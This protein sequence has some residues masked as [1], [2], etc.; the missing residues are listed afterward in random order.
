[1]IGFKIAVV[2]FITNDHVG[3][4][5]ADPN[6]SNLVAVGHGVE[7]GSI[8]CCTAD[9]EF[10]AVLC[11]RAANFWAAVLARCLS[12]D[13]AGTIV[14]STL[15]AGKTF[16]TIA[17]VRRSALADTS[18]SEL[19][20]IIVRLAIGNFNGALLTGPCIR[21]VARVQALASTYA[22][23][24]ILARVGVEIAVSYS[25]ITVDA[26]PCRT[27]ARARVSC[28]TARVARPIVVTWVC[29]PV[30]KFDRHHAAVSAPA[31]ST[32]A[33]VIH[34]SIAHTDTV[35]VTYT[36]VPLTEWNCSDAVNPA[37]LWIA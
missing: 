31:S 11:L 19:T 13:E 22:V 4:V 2:V 23:P 25:S 3:T 15:M 18:A 12:C 6:A 10:L 34:L 5:R 21:T 29:I 14:H 20:R 32:N 33:R 17:C 35:I 27:D 8:K 28:S 37:P 26:T 30:A 36:R 9:T 7:C 24:T 16:G 1:M